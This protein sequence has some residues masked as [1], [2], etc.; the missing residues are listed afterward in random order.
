MSSA[1][2]SAHIPIFRFKFN[3]EVVDAVMRFAKI[4]Q[5][6]DRHEY[7]DAW[8]EWCIENREMLEMEV[9]RLE[10]VGYDGDVY[11][12][13]FKSGR[14]YFR[15]KKLDK[16]APVERKKYIGLS[17]DT[18][19]AMDDYIV[20]VIKQGLSPAD[21]FNAFC[22]NQ[23]DVL[24]TEISTLLNDYGLDDSEVSD[25]LKKTF[26]NRYFQKVRKTAN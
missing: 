5:H 16:A 23:K 22:A 8:K 21:A 13:L 1:T 14:Y 25:K 26:K 18:L 6:N 24:M 3:E 10:L 2:S 4:H 12:K 17:R 7:K 15:T 11:D 20:V 19:R 9:K